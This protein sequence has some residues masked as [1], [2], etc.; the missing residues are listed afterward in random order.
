MLSFS[1]ILLLAFRCFM[2]VLAE[3]ES[4]EHIIII[5]TEED[6]RRMAKNCAFDHWSEGKTF[7]LQKILWIKVW[8]EQNSPFV[9]QMEK[10]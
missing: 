5:E 10:I 1:L 2:P 6:L 7:V 3:E 4:E 9:L 8:K